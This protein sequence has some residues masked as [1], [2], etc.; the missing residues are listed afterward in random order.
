MELKDTPTRSG[1]EEEDT[2]KTHVTYE[3]QVEIRRVD[4][5]TVQNG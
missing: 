3:N 4:T 1:E 2:V 5:P